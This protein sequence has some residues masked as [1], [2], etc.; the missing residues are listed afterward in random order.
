MA[1]GTAPDAPDIRPSVTSATLKPLLCRDDERR[2]QLM[3]LRHAVGARTLIANDD[4]AI[5]RQLAGLEC[6]DHIFLIVEHARW[7]FDNAMLGLDR[8]GL[9]HAAPQVPAQHLQPAIAPNGSVIGRSTSRSPLC[10]GA[11]RHFKSIRRQ[12]GF[13]NT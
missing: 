11:G 1:A 5:A 4:H 10:S 13:S 9:D 7:R 6:L 8:R 3:Q 2:C 12:P